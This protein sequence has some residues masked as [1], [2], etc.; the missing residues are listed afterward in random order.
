MRVLNTYGQA[1]QVLG[2]W[3]DGADGRTVYEKWTCCTDRWARTE[4]ISFDD[5][6]L[7]LAAAQAQ[8][9]PHPWQICAEQQKVA[10]DQFA[11]EWL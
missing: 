2:T 11:A 10:E 8:H 1:T 6:V 9:H 3:R 7:K 5:I 4:S